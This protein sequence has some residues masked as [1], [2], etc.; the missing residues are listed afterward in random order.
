MAAKKWNTDELTEAFRSL[1]AREPESWASSQLEEGIPQLHRFAFL[2]AL[3]E[4]V[5]GPASKV[6]VA[7]ARDGENE[8][9]DEAAMTALKRMKELGVTDDDITNAVRAAHEEQVYFVAQVIDDSAG[10]L[11]ELDYDGDETD[12]QWGLFV[13][14]DKGKPKAPIDSLQESANDVGNR[15]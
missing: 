3:W 4:A 8:L 12:V 9:P 11:A 15:E 1:G 14:D 10:A 6:W 5:D 2:K 7:A 13:I